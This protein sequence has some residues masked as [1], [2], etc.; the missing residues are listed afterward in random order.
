MRTDER[1]AQRSAEGDQ[2]MVGKEEGGAW[3]GGGGVFVQAR[4][5][6]QDAWCI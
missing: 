5:Q 2:E 6:K 1:S 4:R 3:K